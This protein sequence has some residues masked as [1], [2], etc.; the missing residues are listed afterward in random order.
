MCVAEPGETGWVIHAPE[1]V[2]DPG[3]LFDE[4]RLR[5]KARGPVL[6]GFDFPIGLPIAYAE[7]TGFPDFLT[8][9]TSFGAGEWQNW[10]DVADHLE[11]ASVQ[12]P[13]YPRTAGKRGERKRSPWLDQLRLTNA[14][15]LRRCE[16]ATADRRAAC[17]L[18]WTL[19]GNQV[20]R[21]AILGWRQMLV[22]A[23]KDQRI[24]VRLWPFHG[25]L[26]ELLDTADVVVAETYPA[27]IYRW[28]GINLKGRKTEVP[29]LLPAAEPM[30][31]WLQARGVTASDE[32]LVQIAAGFGGRNPDDRFDAVVGCMGMLDVALNVRADGA[33]EADVVVSRWEGWILGQLA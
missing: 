18:F 29:N 24:R 2:A 1:Q 23:L 22:P 20:G 3:D 16:Q 33:P 27:E 6:A 31:R 7:K 9:L 14:Q 5:A 13:F 4:L 25:S 28:L 15:V 26:G 11:Q 12:R 19:G 8:A 32:L 30:R 17:A 21:A 10:F